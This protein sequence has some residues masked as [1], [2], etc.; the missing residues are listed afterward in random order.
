MSKDTKSLNTNRI[1]EPKNI[2]SLLL[3]ILQNS[4]N[5]IL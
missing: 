1:S 4:F 3:G 5:G 2:S